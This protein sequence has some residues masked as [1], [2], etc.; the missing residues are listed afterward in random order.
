MANI[1]KSLFKTKEEHA[2]TG[3]DKTARKNFEI[4]K[5]DGLRAQ[6]MGR[7]DYAVK[8]FVNALKIEE[9]FETMGYLSQIY[10]RTHQLDEAHQMLNRM[11]ELEPEL[12]DTCTT[13][14]H[15]CYMQENY[16]D[17][18]NVAQ[19]AI[20]L[21]NANPQAYYLLAKAHEGLQEDAA[22]IAQLTKAIDLKNDFMEALL[23]R[24]EIWLRMQQNPEA[25]KDIEAALELNAEEETALLLSGKL[26]QATGDEESAENDFKRITALNPF[27]E[28]AYLHLA[29]LYIAQKKLAEA[30]EL[31]DEAIE[32]NP[33][34][35]EAFRERGKVRL[36]N[37]DQDGSEEDMK[38]ALQLSPKETENLNEQFGNPE[39]SGILGNLG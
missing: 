17:M 1:F 33:D 6:R 15:V 8:C 18:A 13:L 29:Q 31:L 30:I 21:D 5:F 7:T 25:R 12:A 28:Q 9:D 24:A 11:R 14:A 2:G 3:Q 27:N 35:A 4:F 10:I 37:G 36:L 16:A 26:H 38:Q 22:A 19:K 34:S 32:L 39:S 23:M 20:E